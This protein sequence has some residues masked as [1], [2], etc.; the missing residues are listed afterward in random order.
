MSEN[1]EN[2]KKTIQV[3]SIANNNKYADNPNIKTISVLC[4]EPEK[5]K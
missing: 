1:K 2:D 5:N 3:K 4:K